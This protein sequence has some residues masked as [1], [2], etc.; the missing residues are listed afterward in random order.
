MPVARP[1]VPNVVRAAVFAALALLLLARARAQDPAD[2]ADH[3]PGNVNEL[4]LAG[5]RP[6][7][8]DIRTAEQRLGADWRHPSADERDVYDW[9]DARRNLEISLEANPRGVIR[10]VTV[11]RAR[12]GNACR[13][14]L[15]PRRFATGRGLRLG[16]SPRQLLAIYG[17]PFFTGLASWRGQTMRLIVFNFSWAGSSK[18]QILESSFDARGRLVKMTL[19]AAYY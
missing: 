10:A 7:Q 15:P 9:C 3:P 6:G 14:S 8:T 4:T 18:P 16:D 19:S 2:S 11:E 17:K 12:A 5:L 13:G 1:F